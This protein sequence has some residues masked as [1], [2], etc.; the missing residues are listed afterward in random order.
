MSDLPTSELER[1]LSDLTTWSGQTPGLWRRAVLAAGP[2]VSA[3]RT[4]VL[5]RRVPIWLVAGAAAALVL[6]AVGLWASQ[7]HKLRGIGQG[8]TVRREPTASTTNTDW[9]PQSASTGESAV[10]IPATLRR[11]YAVGDEVAGA[12]FAT[13]ELDGDAARGDRTMGGGGRMSP[14]AGSATPAPSSGGERGAEP[15]GER[16][17]IRKATIELVTKDVRATFLKATQL[18]S[19]A[20]GEYVQDS[21]LTGEPNRM[22]GN[23]TLRVAAERLPEMLNELRGLGEVRAEK[24]GGE[25][26]TTQV[27]DLEARLRNEQRVEA[28]ML[29][30]LEKRQ[31]AP[32][33]EILELRSA[34][35]GVRQTIEQLTGQRERLGRLVS[36]ATVLVIIRPADAPAQPPPPAPGL[37]AYF[38]RVFDEAWR[39]GLMFL[40]NTL[41]ALLSIFIGGLIWWVLLLIAILWVRAYRRRRRAAVGG[42]P[43]S[44]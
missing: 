15:S 24:S 14:P 39:D 32:L 16:Q 18:I 7:S 5:G 31:D 34:L 35:S 1:Q 12:P 28:E 9:F 29:Q 21:G 19:E 6:F 41:L 36:L 3:Q 44:R 25:D 22:E 43:I 26:V 17:V 2:T 33:K 20:R 42:N 30:L 40:M 27:V 37:G 4:R 11:A 38:L 13:Y 10:G 8:M 23:L